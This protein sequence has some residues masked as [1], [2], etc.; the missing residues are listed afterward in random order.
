MKI[1]DIFKVA[2]GAAIGWGASKL[3]PGPVGAAV[4]KTLSS[5]LMSRGGGADM[6][7]VSGQYI[8][9]NIN[10][11]QFGMGTYESGSARNIPMKLITTNPEIIQAEWDYRLTQYARKAYLQKRIT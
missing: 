6:G 2:A 5:S 10:L 3:I 9:R 11:S 4:G 7:T 8:P 1:K